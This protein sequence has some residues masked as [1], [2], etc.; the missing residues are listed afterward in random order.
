VSTTL[1][2]NA[3]QADLWYVWLDQVEPLL[4]EQYYGLLSPEE[5]A[6]AAR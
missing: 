2:P 5:D 1:A 6:R 3:Q 4:W